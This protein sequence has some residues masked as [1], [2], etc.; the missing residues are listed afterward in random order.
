MSR[1]YSKAQC[2]VLVPTY[3]TFHR[4]IANAMK[5]TEDFLPAT[6]KANMDY[7]HK[8]CAY[9]F[10]RRPVTPETWELAKHGKKYCANCHPVKSRVAD[11]AIQIGM[12]LRRNDITC[13]GFNVQSKKKR[14]GEK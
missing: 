9:V 7:D 1:A 11:V 3:N 12:L 5:L 6:K 4:E 13:A 10:A 2:A 8:K 14:K